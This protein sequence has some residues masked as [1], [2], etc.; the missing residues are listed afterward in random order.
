MSPSLSHADRDHPSWRLSCTSWTLDQL[1][2]QYYFSEEWRYRYSWWRRNKSTWIRIIID[3]A[4]QSLWSECRNWTPA[5]VVKVRAEDW[6]SWS[7]VYV[8]L[9]HM[10]ISS[11]FIVFRIYNCLELLLVCSLDAREVQCR[12][13]HLWV[14]VGC[15]PRASQ[16]LP[17]EVNHPRSSMKVQSVGSRLPTLS[18]P[19]VPGHL[20]WPR[21]AGHLPGS[22][23]VLVVCIVG[24]REL[25]DNLWKSSYRCALSTIPGPSHLTVHPT[26]IVANTSSHQSCPWSHETQHT[27]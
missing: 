17:S 15:K 22:N 27:N 5:V 16:Y 26:I 10:W 23:G 14:P 1:N 19:I 20:K 18:S 7:Y 9:H 21:E 24:T 3:W 8:H 11:F 6:K 12:S 2:L 25:D 13:C 4:D